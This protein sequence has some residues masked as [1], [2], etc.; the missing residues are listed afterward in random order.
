MT[1]TQLKDRFRS[2]M[3]D[4]P[5][6]PDD[7]SGC[8]WSDEEIMDYLDEAQQ[9]FVYETRY[10]FHTIPVHILPG[11][12]SIPLP[13]KLINLRE[14]SMLVDGDEYPIDRS[15]L[16]D[17]DNIIEDYGRLFNMTHASRHRN[18]LRITLDHTSDK[19]TILPPPDNEVEIVLN[20]FVE[21]R[22]IAECNGQM[23]VTN[24]R[25]QRMILSGAKALGYRKQDSQ[26]YNPN[27]MAYFENDYL[28][29]IQEVYGERMRQRR[30]PGT[31]TYGGL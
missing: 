31:I 2:D 15:N 11:E 5:E 17:T 14:A 18:R 23:E 3:D 16:G 4:V 9:K 10:L 25:H 21:A 7:T 27:Q 6:H 24:D 28:L 12:I 30:T 26:T 20:A 1:P 13:R 8:L 19:L 22:P 29:G